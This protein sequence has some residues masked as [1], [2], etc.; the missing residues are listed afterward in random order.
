MFCREIIRT[1]IEYLKQTPCPNA[2][3]GD[4]DSF[5]VEGMDQ[6]AHA[7]HT[8]AG[9]VFGEFQLFVLL[10]SMQQLRDVSGRH[11]GKHTKSH[12]S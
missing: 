12:D 3:L 10:T 11:V 5:V 1:D 8:R 6:L 9:D 4:Y 7:E 2:Y